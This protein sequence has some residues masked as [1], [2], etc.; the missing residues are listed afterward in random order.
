MDLAHEEATKLRGPSRDV[1]KT[2]HGLARGRKL[3]NLLMAVIGWILLA[4]FGSAGGAFWLLAYTEY[5][6]AV[7]WRWSLP[8]LALATISL[9]LAL[10]G[11]LAVWRGRNLRFH[12]FQD[13]FV[14]TRGRTRIGARWSEVKGLLVTAVR[15]GLFG[16]SW[17]QRIQL[18]LDLMDGRKI[19]ISDPMEDEETLINEIKTHTYPDMLE[20][21]RTAFNNG[22]PIVFGPVTINR[23]GVRT[24]KSA[25]AWSD[26]G[27]ATLQSGAI[28]LQPRPYSRARK[29]RIPADSIPNVDLCVQL[30]QALGQRP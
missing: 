18:Q 6:P 28:H 15:Y 17:G 22:H 5:G 11:S 25:I 14:F 16:L 27:T 8:W 26:L 29:V 3:R 1:P 4:G 13:G 19:A 7:V 23:S 24:Q 12:L 30:I 21:Y 20:A 2:V 9:P 10:V